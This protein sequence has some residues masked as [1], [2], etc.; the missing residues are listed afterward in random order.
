L[1]TLNSAPP[2]GADFDWSRFTKEECGMDQKNMSELAWCKSSASGDSNCVEVAFGADQVLV[3]DSKDRDG[4]VLR[5]TF[6]EWSAFVIG[7]RDG[8]FELGER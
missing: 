2:A 6:A 1:S 5:F 3:R 4:T 7:V 8:Q